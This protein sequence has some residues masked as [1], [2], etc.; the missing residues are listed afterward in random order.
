MHWE[1][2]TRPS[3]MLLDKEALMEEEQGGAVCSNPSSVR[4]HQIVVSGHDK[5]GQ[6]WRRSET[7]TTIVFFSWVLE[8]ALNKG[9]LLLSVC[10]H[11]GVDGSLFPKQVVGLRSS[12]V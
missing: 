10:V 5:E 12:L 8:S 6:V 9:W 7:T 2:L 3:W 1:V 11:G 4:G